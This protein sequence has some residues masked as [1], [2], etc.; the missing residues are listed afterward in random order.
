[1]ST[2]TSL[3]KLSVGRRRWW[4]NNGPMGC[5]RPGRGCD[6]AAHAPRVPWCTTLHAGSGRESGCGARG[7]GVDDLWCLDRDRLLRIKAV[8][9]RGQRPRAFFWMLADE[10]RAMLAGRRRT[11]VTVTS[12]PAPQPPAQ[13]QARHAQQRHQPGEFCRRR[14]WPP[15]MAVCSEGRK[16]GCPRRALQAPHDAAPG[17]RASAARAHAL[18]C[19]RMRQARRPRAQAQPG[20][21]ARLGVCRP[22]PRWPGPP[23]ADRPWQGRGQAPAGVVGAMRQAGRVHH[24]GRH[25]ADYA[26]A[27]GPATRRAGSRTG[28]AGRTCWPHRPRHR[29]W[30]A[31]RRAR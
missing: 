7:A 18:G 24:R 22:A 20:D 30:A 14:R 27:A 25:G 12:A 13:G 21:G 8:L 9:N 6:P 3:S 31:S 10:T 26:P 2:P 16:T 29:A 15:S 23:R 4:V 17:R 28:R 19:Q 1:M 11:L 5:G